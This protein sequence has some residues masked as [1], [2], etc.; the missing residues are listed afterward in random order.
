MSKITH[1]VFQS[2]ER[3]PA[4][5][6][7]D[8]IPDYWVTLYVTAKLR[9]S[10]TANAIENI[11]R[12]ILH[13]KLWETIE[14]R[15]VIAEIIDGQLPQ[16]DDIYSLRDHCLVQ[17]RSLKRMLE[18]KPE[19]NAA[20]IDQLFPTGRKTL[21][22][23]RKSHYANRL[24]H[25]A[26]FIDFTAK[27]IMRR[28]SDYIQKT[29]EI[30][31]V[32]KLIKAQKKKV[33]KHN[34]TD[35]SEAP[36]PEVFESFMEFVSDKNPD[37]PFQDPAIRFRNSL[38]FQIL[39]D[40]GCRSGELL[41]L[42]I[43]DIDFINNRIN[44]VRRHDTVDDWRARQ[45][46]AKT[47]ERS[48]PVKSELIAQLRRYIIEVRANVPFAT[49]HPYIFVSHKKGKYQGH[50]I[51]NS[52]FRDRIL[53]AAKKKRPELYQGI[54]RH[55]FRH[56]FNYRLSI[57]IDA[58][59]KSVDKDGEKAKAEGKSRITEAQEIQI[60][61]EINGWSS[62]GSAHL[63]NRRHIRE[64]AQLLMLSDMDQQ[65]NSTTKG[66]DNETS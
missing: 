35:E 51:S 12:N 13:F 3:Y 47:L 33:N 42:R 21:P 20:K 64:K 6:H 7:D 55:G 58:F 66:I 40:T 62:E 1:L 27:C 52:N 32:V 8:G 57:K 28:R 60:R 65:F 56:N 2:G 23:V 11:I 41:G 10:H 38:I 43:D 46:V 30:N 63:Y 36:P 61:K 34:P 16:P 25:I 4:L 26:D 5:I 24:T 50:P 15:D 39:Y 44:I 9:T 37:N 59:N 14:Q 48:I 49:K 54:T 18:S 31:S 45:P 29:E 53:G 22:R 19:G 17:T